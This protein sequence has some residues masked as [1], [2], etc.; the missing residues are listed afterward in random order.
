MVHYF[1][2]P[3]DRNRLQKNLTNPHFSKAALAQFD[4]QSE[5]FSW[6]FPGIL[7]QPLSLRFHSRAHSGQ[8]VA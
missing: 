1:L 4:L 8:S 3:R 2:K 7:G 5:G 6:D